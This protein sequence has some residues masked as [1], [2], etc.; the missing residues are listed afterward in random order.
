[1]CNNQPLNTQVDNV[2]AYFA[3]S[4]VDNC[5]KCAAFAE[6][7]TQYIPM[8]LK[9]KCNHVL[10]VH[11]LLF[12]DNQWWYKLK[13][14]LVLYSL[15]TVTWTVVKHITE[16]CMMVKQRPSTYNHNVNINV[17]VLLHVH[18]YP[19]DCLTWPSINSGFTKVIP[20]TTGI[21]RPILP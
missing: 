11:T 10:D 21:A 3:Y 7:N 9:M 5:A 19:I 15:H 14:C 13:L 18:V 17:H 6:V 12:T 1:M 8:N 4:T 2:V 16:H 20:S